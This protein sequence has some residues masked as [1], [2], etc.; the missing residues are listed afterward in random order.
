MAF[1]EVRANGR[2]RG[3]FRDATGRKVWVPGTFSSKR[4]A[5]RA[6]IDAE[7]E[8]RDAKPKNLAAIDMTWGEW[9]EAWWPT[10]AIEPATADNEGSMVRNHI[11]PTWAD[12][13]L[14]DINRHDVQAWATGLTGTLGPASVKRVLGVM[15]S[16][17]SAAIDAE[18]LDSNPANRIKLPPAPQ[19]KEVYLTRAQFER[20]ADAIPYANDTAIVQML[21]G[22]G[23]RWGELAGLHWHN[24]DVDGG[25]V[26]VADV[27][28]A[29]E[30]K[31]YPKGRRQRRV[32]VFEFSFE[33][34]VV[35]AKVV[36]CNVPHRHG[37][38]PSGLVFPSGTNGALD[39][40][41]FYRRVME[42][43]MKKAD[44]D[45]LGA[46]LHD[47]RHTYAS[48]LV[49]AGVPLERIALL[50]GHASTNT[51]QIY[52]HLAPTQ[53]ADLAAVFGKV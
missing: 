48:W 24:L 5:M 27:A 35:P 15:V 19:G 12:V 44:L 10:R 6:A 25:M 11:A 21:A 34:L 9:C 4:A 16:S 50:L 33:N 38:C 29:G 36:P 14:A 26:T 51:T 52:A 30:I 18:L 17:L 3:G 13:P 28:S 22:T 40:R 7:A 37:K 46:T 41:N 39:D 43:A 53:H 31:P 42:P 49:Q 23:M 2:V 8:A 47:L 20:F 1:T 32:P 45:G